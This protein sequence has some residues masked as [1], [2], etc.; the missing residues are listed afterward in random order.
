MST[1]GIN[2]D[3]TLKP[4]KMLVVD[5][6]NTHAVRNFEMSRLMYQKESFFQ[7]TET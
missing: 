4:Y 3:R 1:R 5:K 2:E 7:V 6:K